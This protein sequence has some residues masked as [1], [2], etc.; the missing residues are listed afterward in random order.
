MESKVDKESAKVSFECASEES[1][2]SGIYIVSDEKARADL[3]KLHSDA[4]SDGSL[5]SQ[6]LA[7]AIESSHILLPGHKLRSFDDL[8]NMRSVPS[9]QSTSI[10]RDERPS[11]SAGTG[12]SF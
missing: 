5:A 6:M 1:S 12:P 3:V 7:S 4:K 8:S 11:S 9:D 2:T 10:D